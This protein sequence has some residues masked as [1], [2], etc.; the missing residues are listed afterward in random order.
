MKIE[1]NIGTIS[2]AVQLSFIGDILMEIKDQNKAEMW[3][4]NQQGR[5]IYHTNHEQIGTVE[6]INQY[7]ITNGSFY[8]I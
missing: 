1:K 2:L 8:I 6:D 5:V 7:P 3:V 4:M